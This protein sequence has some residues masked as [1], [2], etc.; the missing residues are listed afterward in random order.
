MAVLACYLGQG[1]LLAIVLTGLL[2]GRGISQ[3]TIPLAVITALVL[4]RFGLLWSADVLAQLAGQATQERLRAAAFGKL[5]ELGPAYTAGARTGE[6]RESLVD[7]ID[8]LQSYYGSYLP[9]LAAGLL[10]PIAVIVILASQDGW[11]ALLVGLF[12]LAALVLPPLWRRPL[13]T[14]GHER[15][16]AYLGLGAQFLDTLQGMVTLKTFG[17]TARRR[18]QLAETSQM[19]IAQWVREM[20]LALVTGGIY[21]LAITGGLLAVAVVAAIRVAEQG[22]AVGTMF[23]ALF[24]TFEALRPFGILAGAFHQNYAATNT[25]RRI[26]NLLAAPAPAPQRPG[27]TKVPTPRPQVSFEHVT[28]GYGGRQPPV[29][30]DF[31]LDVEPGQTVAIVGPSGAGKT[32]L[33]SLLLRFVDPQAGVVRIGGHDLRELPAAQLRQMVALV[34]QDTYLFGGTV[35]ENLLMARPAATVAEIEAAARVAN[36]HEFLAALPEGYDTVLGERGHGLSG[37]QRQR[38]AIAR[39]VLADAPVLVLDEATAS[40]DAATEA[41]IQSA[42]DRVTIGRTTLVVAHRLSTV[43]HADRIVVLDAGRVVEAGRHEELLRRDGA[44]A[45]LVA[46][47]EVPA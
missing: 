29:L 40:V 45:R 2:A 41:A 35:R 5:A 12:A 23:L 28:F 10:A 33:V 36:A 24:L 32:T 37:G 39:A 7:G 38:L 46:T 25:A 19:L 47:Q 17:A 43:R 27:L 9:S 30:A 18:R 31:S 21:A 22:L 20:A 42:L 6:I 11:L 34:A 3:Q 44:Y 15:M 14:R 4:V 13:T 16:S 1:I 26:H 8:S